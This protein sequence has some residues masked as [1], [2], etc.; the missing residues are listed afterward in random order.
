MTH[1]HM[2]YKKLLISCYKDRYV[3]QPGKK[4]TGQVLFSSLP[5]WNILG[6]EICWAWQNL[7]CTSALILWRNWRLISFLFGFMSPVLAFFERN[8]EFYF[9]KYENEPWREVLGYSSLNPKF[10]HMAKLAVDSE[11]TC[12]S[13]EPQF[14]RACISGSQNFRPSTGPRVQDFTHP[15]LCHLGTVGWNLPQTRHE[16]VRWSMPD[17]RRVC[18]LFPPRRP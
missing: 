17:F 3:F 8:L 11:N 1:L 16:I 7:G 14:F 9:V 4:G 15:K 6:L 18:F 5:K 10:K 12:R 13:S 2:V